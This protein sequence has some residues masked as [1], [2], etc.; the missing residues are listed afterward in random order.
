MLSWIT[1]PRVTNLAE[2]LDVPGVYK[3]LVCDS[4]KLTE[5]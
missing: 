5:V 3:T 1:G 4:D 2:D